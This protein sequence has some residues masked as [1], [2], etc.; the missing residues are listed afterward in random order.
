MAALRGADDEVLFVDVAAIIAAADE[1]LAPEDRTSFDQV[2][3][4]NLRPIDAIVAGGRS[5]AAGSTGRLVVL[6]R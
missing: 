4:P 5:S 2:I 3:A 1:A 6:V